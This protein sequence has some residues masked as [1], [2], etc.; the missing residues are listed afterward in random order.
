MYRRNSNDSVDVLIDSTGVNI[1]HTGGGHSK[2][3]SNTRKFNG[4]DQVRKLH[5]AVDLN[6]KDVLAVEMTSG[7]KADSELLPVLIDKIPNAIRSVYADG[8]YQN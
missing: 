3:N 4:F 7:I 2:E 1:Y 8:A 6:S 5:I